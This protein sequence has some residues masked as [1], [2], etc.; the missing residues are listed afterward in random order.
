MLI[1]SRLINQS[2]PTPKGEPNGLEEI[3]KAKWS[4]GTAVHIRQRALKAYIA[5]IKRGNKHE[6]LLA[7]VKACVGI[8]KPGTVYAPLLSTWLNEERWKDAAGG[9]YQSVSLV[10]LCIRR[11][12]ADGT[13]QIVDN[14]Q[15]LAGKVRD[16]VLPGV[17]LAPPRS[18]PL[19]QH[20]NDSLPPMAASTCCRLQVSGAAATFSPNCL[21][22]IKAEPNAIS[23]IAFS[24]AGNTGVPHD[25]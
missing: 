7:A 17:L 3:W 25:N 19:P 13:T 22:L 8:D 2:P 12:G 6:D 10:R 16:R 18:R 9:T 24:W 15:Q 1:L 11:A 14:L 4:R 20:N 23:Q 5:T 21:T